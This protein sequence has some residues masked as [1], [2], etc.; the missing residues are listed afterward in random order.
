M[1]PLAIHPDDSAA[2]A[3]ATLPAEHRV[4][5]LQIRMLH[6]KIKLVWAAEL[7]DLLQLQRQQ[8]GLLSCLGGLSGMR[9]PGA[10]GGPWPPPHHNAR[11]RALPDA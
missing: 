10:S 4:L 6:Q 9:G 7:A 11:E 3:A 2:S 5:E 8:L 1:D